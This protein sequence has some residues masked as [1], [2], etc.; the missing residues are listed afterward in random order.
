MIG[1]QLQAAL[2]RY[3][4]GDLAPWLS[5]MIVSNASD[6]EIE[7]GLRE[8]PAFRTRFW[9]IFEREKAGL[10]PISPDWVVEYEARVMEGARALGATV[11]REQIGRLIANNVSAEE[12]LNRVSIAATAVYQSPPETRAALGRLY[13]ITH[14]DMVDYWLDP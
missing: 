14:A 12:S 9:M 5:E 10:S 6:A 1:P 3:G 8:Q 2:A 7:L 4:L 13:G 11:T